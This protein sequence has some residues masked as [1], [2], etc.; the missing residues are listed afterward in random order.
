MWIAGNLKCFARHA[1]F[2]SVDMLQFALT[3]SYIIQ[4]DHHVYDSDQLCIHDVQ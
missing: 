4:H 3:H 1:V 2:S